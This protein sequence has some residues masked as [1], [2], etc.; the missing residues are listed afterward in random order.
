M[1][2]NELNELNEQINL[3]TNKHFIKS[4]YSSRLYY[5]KQERGRHDNASEP[6]DIPIPISKSL[7]NNSL[8]L[9]NIKS[10]YNS[11][12]EKNNHTTQCLLCFDPNCKTSYHNDIT[13]YCKTCKIFIGSAKSLYCIECEKLL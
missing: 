8:L 2:F 3:S 11:L 13:R 6:I 1:N 7:P 5:T 12:D 4:K 9:S 10:K